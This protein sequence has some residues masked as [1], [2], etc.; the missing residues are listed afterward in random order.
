MNNASMT[1]AVMNTAVMTTSVTDHDNGYLNKAQKSLHYK[2]KTS[3]DADAC[4]D[5][6]LARFEGLHPREAI[7]RLS[8]LPVLPH[9]A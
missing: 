1:T 6:D 5:Q 2:R 7:T 9:A 4:Q 3:G 8:A